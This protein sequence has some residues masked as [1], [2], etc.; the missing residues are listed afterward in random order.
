[1]SQKVQTFLVDDLDGST[2]LRTVRF[3]IDGAE[4][5]ID[6]NDDHVARLRQTLDRYIAAGRKVGKR[7]SHRS[8]GNGHSGPSSSDVRQWAQSQGLDVKDRGRLPAEMK[9]KFLD[10]I[11]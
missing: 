1:M 2:A 3:G 7:A 4:Y 9:A 5:E 6:L 8:I 10:S 11:G